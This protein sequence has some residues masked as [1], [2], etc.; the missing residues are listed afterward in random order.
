ML[1]F[2]K[3]KLDHQSIT[4][5]KNSSWVFISNA[6]G[7]ALA[8]LRSV[9]IARSIGAEWYGIF[10]VMIVFIGTI[11]ETMNLNLGAAVIRFG[12]VF[13][14]DKNQPA[15]VALIKLSLMASCVVALLS[16]SVI[17]A[18]SQFQYDTFIKSPNLSWFA[19]LY[20]VAASSLFFNQISR[21][22]LRLYFKF[23][24]NSI[25]QMVMDVIEFAIIAIALFIKPGEFHY[26]LIAVLVARFINSIIPNLAAFWELAPELKAD[27]NTPFNSIKEHFRSIRNFVFRNS[28]A[29]TLQALIKNGDIILITFLTADP[30]QVALYSVGKKV[31]FSILTVTDPLVTSI[32]PQLCD[33][34]NENKIIQIKKMVVRLTALAAIPSAVFFMIAFLFNEY[35]MVT[36]FGEEYR[37]AGK[38]FYLLTGASLVG[39]ILFWVQ[40]LL[41]AIDLLT[42]RIG[43]YLAGIFVG[44][45][46]AYLLIP[47]YG[48][49]GMAISMIVMNTVMPGMF[50]Y[51]AIQKL[52]TKMNGNLGIEH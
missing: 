31:A 30:V 14:T 41:Q 34:Y 44:L 5:F 22:A 20:A 52:N 7:A 50:V 51:F 32:Y 15:V 24:L 18:L 17:Y 29:K 26:F 33:L 25:I 45:I 38:T 2:F 39:A 19:I 27:L 42:I 8:L 11:Q 23:K 35:I 1:N 6:F 43:I 3:R 40:P 13:K 4:L 36:V 21:G 16:V 49:Y 37:P 46:S 12:S 9:I 28:I 10:T 48:S 47:E